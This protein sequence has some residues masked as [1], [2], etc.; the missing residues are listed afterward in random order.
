MLDKER[1]IQKTTFGANLQVIANF[2]N[3]NFEYEK[4]IIPANSA[5][6][7]QDWKNKI[8]STENLDS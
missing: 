5:M 1:L 6:S 8:I 4:K 2:S 7:V 3:K